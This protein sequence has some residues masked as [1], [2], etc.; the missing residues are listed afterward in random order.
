MEQPG[1]GR[2]STVDAHVGMKLKDRRILLGLNQHELGEAVDVSI[3]QIQKYESAKNR[4]SSGK[5]YSFAKLLKVPISYFFEGVTSLQNNAELADNHHNAFAEDQAE[6]IRDEDKVPDKEIMNL[7]K[8][9]KKIDNESKR[10]G[11]FDLVKA[12]A[13]SSD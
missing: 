13:H 12:L 11:V 2:V 6:F 10:K 1:K 8:A 7:V 4:I 5:L 9:Y 3:Q